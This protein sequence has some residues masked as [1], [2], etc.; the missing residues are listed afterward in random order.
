MEFGVRVLWAVFVLLV[1]MCYPCEARANNRKDL[2][3]TP[4]TTTDANNESRNASS[5]D[6]RSHI[7]FYITF[8]R[9]VMGFLLVYYISS[10]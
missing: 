7:R 5:E 1:S 8:L 9:I 10:N 4:D 2:R 3:S 6:G